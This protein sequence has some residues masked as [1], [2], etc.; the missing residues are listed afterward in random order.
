MKIKYSII[1]PTYNR[2]KILHKCL[3]HI[4]ELENPSGNC[5]VLVMDNNSTDNTEEVI[6]TYKEKLPQLKY[7]LTTSPG[8]HIGRN[9]GYE[10]ASGEILCYI[11]D[12]SFVS[13]GWLKG[14]EKAF[15]DPEV[16]L[17]GGPC[18]P[19]YESNPPKWINKLWNKIGYGKSLGYLS[20]IDCGEKAK[21][22]SAF[23]ILGCNFIVRKEILLQLEGFHPDGMPMDLVLYR[24]DGESYVSRRIIEM[25]ALVK[26]EP[27]VMIHHFIPTSRMNFKYFCTRSFYQG[28]SYSFRVV[29]QKYG[30][31]SK[32]PIE[33]YLR[34]NEINIFN[35]LYSK[36]ENFI[37]LI[38]PRK[39]ARMKREIKKKYKLGYLYHQNTIKENSKLLE[40]VL[41]K[42]YL[43]K[44]G[45]IPE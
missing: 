2:A 13:K 29:R 7:F 37:H 36:C 6:K 19:K 42:N 27:E 17:V 5:E 45:N 3:K 34:K 11:D 14:I 4:Y 33:V 35:R 28:I 9:L 26:Y 43:G 30:L 10:K 39:I 23:Y 12:D 21:E 15:L 38:D 31:Y 20:L 1:I 41:R 40:W 44:D 24:G 18:L 22:I 32:I 16:I 25:N 8:L